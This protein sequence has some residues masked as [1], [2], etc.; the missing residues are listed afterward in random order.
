MAKIVLK[1]NEKKSSTFTFGKADDFPVDLVNSETTTKRCWV[2]LN[3][4]Q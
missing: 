2:L 1:A 4:T 3:M